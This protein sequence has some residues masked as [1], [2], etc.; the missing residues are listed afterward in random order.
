MGYGWP[1]GLRPS[2]PPLLPRLPRDP[3]LLLHRLAGL[4]GQRSGE[5]QWLSPVCPKTGYASR[6]CRSK[7]LTY[8]QWISEVLHFCQGLPIILVGCKK[9]LRYDPKTIEELRKTS[10]KP[11][12]PEEVR[13]KR[14]VS[15]RHSSDGTGPE[16]GQM[17]TLRS[18]VRKS[19]RRSVPTSTSSAL[20]GPTR[21]SARCLSMLRAPPSCRARAP[22]A[23]R[24]AWSFKSLYPRDKF[25]RDCPALYDPEPR[26]HGT[27][28]LDLVSRYG[29][30][31][32]I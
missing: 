2:P 7:L 22:S 19:A 9:D 20:P 14:P 24:S 12:S 6:R 10:Q 28:P 25:E 31:G 15:A 26:S 23:T 27:W 32:T 8:V 21:A 30:R 11:V 16:L 17:L 4:A 18:R 3:D 13:F 1:G 5:G 29:Y